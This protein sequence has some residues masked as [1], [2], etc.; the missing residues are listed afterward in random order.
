MSIKNDAYQLFIYTAAFFFYNECHLL[1]FFEAFSFFSMILFLIFLFLCLSFWIQLNFLL[2]NSAQLSLLRQQS[3]NQ[4]C[5]FLFLCFEAQMASPYIIVPTWTLVGSFFIY[6]A[7]LEISLG[8]M[9]PLSL[10]KIRS[11]LMFYNS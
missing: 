11:F 7:L 1:A 10:S 5:R 6:V 4:L 9:Q 2:V 8:S 3:I